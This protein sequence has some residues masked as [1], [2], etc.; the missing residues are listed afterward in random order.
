MIHTKYLLSP[1]PYPTLA[2]PHKDALYVLLEKLIS[3]CS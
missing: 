3:S 1:V 2:H